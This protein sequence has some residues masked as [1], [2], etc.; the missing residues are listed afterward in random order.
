MVG[1]VLL[2]A[3][4][5]FAGV[6]PSSAQTKDLD[7]V[8]RD[9]FAFV[10][11]RC[12]EVW[13]SPDL[14][15]VRE[16]AMTPADGVGRRFE[17][18]SSLSPGDIERITLVWPICTVST[19]G[20]VPI[21][22]VTLRK[23]TEW[24]PML[25]R[26]N[27]LDFFDYETRRWRLSG[28]DPR[29]KPVPQR[30]LD[31][32][33]L[34]VAESRTLLTAIDDRTLLLVP[35][36]H[37]SSPG[38]AA[39]V[40]QLLRKKSEGPLSEALAEGGKHT[41]VAGM[42]VPPAAAL[43]ESSGA[44]RGNHGF[45]PLL[46][47]RSAMLFA[48]LGPKATLRL[49]AHF[50]DADSA[51]AAAPA[52]KDIVA[53]WRRDLENVLKST[54]KE[55]LCTVRGPLIEPIAEALEG[56]KIE[57]IESSVG[58]VTKV[59]L[60]PALAKSLAAMPGR[61]RES[62]DL[63]QTQNNLKQIG[64]AFHNFE[65]A[66]AFMPNNV[67]SKDGKALLSWRVQLLPYLEQEPLYRQ[68]QL[69]EPWDSPANKKLIEKMPKIYVLPG[70]ETKEKGLTYFQMFSSPEAL[71]D[72]SPLLVA[73]KRWVLDKITDGAS[74]TSLVT[75]AQEPVIW[76]KPDDIVYDPK[77]LPKLGSP[78][79]RRVYFLFADGSSRTMDRDLL[80]DELLKALITADGGETIRA[81]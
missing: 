63:T 13:D 3:T 35:D 77:K 52:I 12:S 2:A 62:E 69:D 51:K 14:K 9:G 6:S 66:F 67:T 31:P 28:S 72:G 36:A 76:T 53:S 61:I 47:A 48:D 68:F 19:E 46:K 33:S 70:R 80:T 78:A 40:G 75:E 29:I 64:L 30:K 25:E 65:S 55:D 20:I 74:N 15:P 79:R 81:P 43:A 38:L 21:L 5:F 56:A 49:Q 17:K 45:A 44:M 41:L 58:V 73:G 22:A 10:T 32:N 54:P 26:L 24:R 16:A 57:V 4:A 34:L 1:R 39:L 37:S 42:F 50:G 11:I 7:W 59:S 23:P 60:A 18:W 71:N 8:P 27:A